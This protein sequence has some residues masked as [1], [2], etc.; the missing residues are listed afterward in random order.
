MLNPDVDRAIHKIKDLMDKSEKPILVAIDGRSGTGKSTIAKTIANS[1][2]GTEIISD[3]FWIGGSNDLWDTRT[4]QEKADLAID[5]E[6]LRKEVL[7]PLLSN[8]SAS[9]Y[10][11]D[12]ESGRGLS[13]K[14]IKKNPTK[15]IV[16]DGAYSTRPELQD[17]IDLSVLVKIHDDSV[18]RTRLVGREGE[19]YMNDWHR[20]WDPAEEHYFKK[21]RPQSDFDII[22]TN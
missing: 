21:I 10:P 16:L 22:I 20:R 6:R 14:K 15:L 4:P 13:S 5:W 12:W 9:W 2:G 17:I 3:D 8:K 18:R 7:E 11:F 1:L 19:T